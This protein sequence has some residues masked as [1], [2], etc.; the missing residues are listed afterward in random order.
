MTDYTKYISKPL[1][2]D[3]I[4]YIPGFNDKYI[5]QL[6]DNF[7]TT[8]DMKPGEWL[9]KY[10]YNKQLRILEPLDFDL[11]FKRSSYL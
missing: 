7:I 8:K 10:E 4:Q 2:V 9:V 1:Y 3:A 5:N 6:G 11:Q